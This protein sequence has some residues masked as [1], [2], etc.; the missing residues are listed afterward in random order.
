MRATSRSKLSKEKL[1]EQQR[2]EYWKNRPPEP[3]DEHGHALQW[4][5]ATPEQQVKI[6]EFWRYVMSRSTDLS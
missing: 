2:E 3:V 1:K 6:Q 5:K 4:D